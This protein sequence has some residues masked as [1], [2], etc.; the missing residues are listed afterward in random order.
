MLLIAPNIGLIPVIALIWTPPVVFIIVR[1]LQIGFIIKKVEKKI[2]KNIK[3]IQT[4]EEALIFINE[5]KK[6]I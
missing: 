6:I 1:Q 4:S 3:M 2:R 5:L